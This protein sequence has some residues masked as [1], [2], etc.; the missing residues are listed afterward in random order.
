MPIPSQQDIEQMTPMMRQYHE[1]KTR[2]GDAVLFF[3][4]GD[5]FEVFG[6][7]ALQVAPELEIVLTSRER[8][9]DKRE[10][11]CGVPH[12]SARNYW[13]RLLKKGYKVAIADQIEDPA[14]AKGLVKRDIVRTLTP[15]CVD[16]LESLDQ[17]TPNYVMAVHE[18]PETRVWCLALADISTG[19]FRLG[20]VDQFSAIQGYTER[21][22][23]REILARKFFH[24]DLRKLLASHISEF[25]LLIE[26]LPEAPLR[27]KNEQRNLLLEVFKSKDLTSQPC[28]RVKSGE[29]VI[30]AL[31]THFKSLQASVRS[32]MTIRPLAEAST[33]HLDETVIRDL[34]LFET[35]RR[36]QADGSLFRE[37]NYTVSP[38]GARL[39]RD[40]LIH[41]L[42]SPKDIA[43][44]HKAVATLEKMGE[45]ALSDIRTH[46]K[47][48]PDLERLS[49]RVLS[50]NASPLDLAR[51]QDTLTRIGWL[52]TATAEVEKELGTNAQ[53]APVR[54]LSKFEKP[55]RV[56]AKALEPTPSALGT[57]YGVF[58]TGFDAELDRCNEL[59]RGGEAKVEAYADGLRAATGI[60]SLKIKNHKSFGLLIEVT[61]THQSKVPSYF[62][63]RQTMVNCERFV[64]EDLQ[65]LNEE[66]V[67]AS[68]KAVA[69]E[70]ELYQQLLNDLAEF[71]TTLKD[72]ATAVA[73]FDMFLSFAWLALRQ[74]YVRP[75]LAKD[76]T[77]SLKASRH[78]VVERYVGKHAFAAND[79]EMNSEARHLL[80][81][82]PNMA[83]KSTVMRQ[84]AL[85]AILNQTGCYVP[86]RQAKLPVFDNIFTRVGAADDLSRGQS[87]F[88][89]EMSE[90]AGILRNATAKSL[91]ILDEVGRGTSTEDGLAIAYAILKDLAGR[92]GCYSLFATHYHELVDLCSSMPHVAAMQTEVLEENASIVFTHRLVPGAAGSSYGIEVAR[93]AGV[94]EEVIRSAESFIKTHR[95]ILTGSVP[96]KPVATETP[97]IPRAAA[98]R[99][100]Q[101]ASPLLPLE[102]SGMLTQKRT[103]AESEIIEKLRKLNINRLTP[104]QAI[105]I[106]NDLQES[107]TAPEPNGLFSEDYC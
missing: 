19:E 74:D 84:V 46:L 77:L 66:L 106:I 59:S 107:L 18:D 49:A 87:T 21:F 98:S 101:S 13:H 33:M 104:L 68:D 78:P 17:D 94:N 50:G 97:V 15:G 96:V 32:F 27:D 34:E 47:N 99:S 61:R 56:L 52:R 48:L 51:I 103:A 25:R 4:M 3:R 58:R 8:G 12:H 60:T 91:V 83:G 29:A 7:D 89:V 1:L 28:G 71:R 76:G 86:A 22:R 41:P 69:R 67:S 100:P 92:V 6:D 73:V 70:V 53:T 40:S 63:R 79:I 16:D 9:D 11:F 20:S 23:P 36:R 72:L 5:F 45:A 39:L 31:I 14:E 82:G 44:R 54:S 26:P 37:I 95:T 57:G 102:L 35:V 90:A 43:D 64:T 55:L 93:I 42:A 105:N 38:M 10:P 2:C 85:I 75:T 80:I 30:A 24:D 65:N 88:M 62:I 81:T